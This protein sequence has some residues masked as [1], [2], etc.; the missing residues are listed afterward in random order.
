MSGTYGGDAY[1]AQAA[2]AARALIDTQ[3]TRA[4]WRD[5]L[6]RTSRR[7][8]LDT[9][10]LR[11]QLA[12]AK[13]V[14][15][16]LDPQKTAQLAAGVA[17]AMAALVALFATDVSLTAGGKPGTMS[18][19]N[20]K[21]QYKSARGALKQAIG[22]AEP[23]FRASW[24]NE[25]AA[26]RKQMGTTPMMVQAR[27]FTPQERKKT[28]EELIAEW[29]EQQQA[30]VEEQ[31]GSV[32]RAQQL[33]EIQELQDQLLA[34]KAA[35]TTAREEDLAPELPLPEETLFD[36]LVAI[37]LDHPVLLGAGVLGAAG[38]F[39]ALLRLGQRT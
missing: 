27:F 28:T 16:V 2:A 39:Y 7:L 18:Y 6:R 12:L 1:Y 17:Q 10:V 33:E 15:K 26:A 22:G 34:L 25:I 9:S 32:D 31:Q 5:R 13:W 30:L 14:G 24:A 36:R 4:K 37:P 29:A 35:A 19:R 3:E 21:R 23:D 20:A 8:Q 11:T 38:A